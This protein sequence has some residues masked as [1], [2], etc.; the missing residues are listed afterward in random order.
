[1]KIDLP[2]A[3]TGLQS[4]ASSPR[5]AANAD[6]KFASFAAQLAARSE[7]LGVGPLSTSP[8]SSRSNG[9]ASNIDPQ[10][11]ASDSAL[12]A[13][14]AARAERLRT[15]SSASPPSGPPESS[16]NRF[17]SSVLAS[18]RASHIWVGSLSLMLFAGVTVLA[19][20]RLSS[21]FSETLPS[22]RIEQAK[23]V[24]AHA[25]HMPEKAAPSVAGPPASAPPTS[26]LP[27]SAL[28]AP[29]ELAKATPDS[30]PKS[31]P[32]QTPSIPQATSTPLTRDEIMEL[33]LILKAL[34]FGPGPID[35]AMGPTTRSALRKYAE[36]RA[37]PN[38]E[39]TR[40]LLSH[41]RAEPR[42]N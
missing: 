1:M 8:P 20:W 5:A 15:G 36:E 14:L 21:H 13:Q 37:M 30:P 40:D 10:D 24:I 3:P 38:A 19:V 33:Q 4:T 35:G 9:S 27:V 25:D 2:K 41:L 22:T 32:P 12:A 31:S 11:A 18:V 17:V 16:T 39:A 6:D 34:G 7:R 23:S 29:Q 28:P 42:P 26:V